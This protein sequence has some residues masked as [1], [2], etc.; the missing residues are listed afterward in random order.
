ML[1]PAGID[2]ASE[3]WKMLTMNGHI[4]WIEFT[5][6]VKVSIEHL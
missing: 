5:V 1:T 6:V 2:D 4:L 3:K